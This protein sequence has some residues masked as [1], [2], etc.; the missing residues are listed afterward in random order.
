MGHSRFLYKA[1]PAS[2]DPNNAILLLGAIE[3]GHS[4]MCVYMYDS[5]ATDYVGA[6]CHI[7]VNGAPVRMQ[8]MQ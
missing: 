1:A 5:S 6:P 4:I 7:M 8:A 2:G 3:Y